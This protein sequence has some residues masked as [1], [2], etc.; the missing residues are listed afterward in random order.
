VGNAVIFPHKIPVFIDGI[1]W[2]V[3]N[4][5]VKLAVEKPVRS[6]APRQQMVLV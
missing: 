5:L 2:S 3:A 1:E 6:A 4:S